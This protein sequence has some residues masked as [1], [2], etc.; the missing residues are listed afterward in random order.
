MEAVAVSSLK[1]VNWLGERGI[2]RKKGLYDLGVLLDLEKVVGKV[3]R[4]VKSNLDC[5]LL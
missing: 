4:D 2:K 3:V 5:N 1:R